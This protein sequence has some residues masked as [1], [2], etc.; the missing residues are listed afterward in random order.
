M[1][2]FL[3]ILMLLDITEVKLLHTDLTS[4]EKDKWNNVNIKPK[5]FFSVAILSTSAFSL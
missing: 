4:L 2:S 5:V 1:Y 3:E